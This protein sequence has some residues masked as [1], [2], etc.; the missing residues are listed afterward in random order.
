MIIGVLISAASSV[1]VPLA[2]RATSAA[3]SAS[4]GW[5]NSSDSGRPVASLWRSDSW[6]CSRV[7]R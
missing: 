4:C 5:P 2:T 7:A 3:V 6:N 1:A